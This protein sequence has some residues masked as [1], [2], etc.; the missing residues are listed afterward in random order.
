MDALNTDSDGTC[1]TSCSLQSHHTL[2]TVYS[3]RSCGSYK[4]SDTLDTLE[5]LEALNTLV[6]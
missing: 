6:S 4:T 2:L 1:R 5:A 3:L